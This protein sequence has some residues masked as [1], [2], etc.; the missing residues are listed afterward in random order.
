MLAKQTRTLAVRSLLLFLSLGGYTLSSYS[1]SEY[2]FFPKPY[3]EHSKTIEKSYDAAKLKSLALNVL[4][5]DLLMKGTS[6]QNIVF[7]GKVCTDSP[8]LLPH[9]QLEEE[10]SGDHLVLTVIIP[11][12]EYDPE[13]AFVDIEISIPENLKT[14]LADSSGDI[15]ASQIS[16]AK[17]DDDSGDI[18]VEQNRTPLVIHD[19]SGDITV[20]SSD[21]S[22]EVTDSSGDIR[23]RDIR[24]SINI[25]TDASGD[26]LIST[27]QGPV[28]IEVDS[29]GD[30]EIDDVESD[31]SIGMDSS[32]DIEIER[33]KGSV[34]IKNDGSGS[35]EIS[36]V[37]GNV[38][39]GYVGSG[40][41][42]VRDVGGDFTVAG[43]G[44]GGIRNYNVKGKVDVPR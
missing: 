9:I 43:K 24:S 22:I 40:R 30:I 41:L 33:I 6:A 28:Q 34:Y 12:K 5:G 10:L 11:R 4:A 37:S 35:I 26:I 8:D 25:P 29:S 7:Q 16:L 44:S 39:V 19:S 36:E 14:V 32:G 27:I 17:I 42:T 31:V 2:S 20:M 21:H 38:Q 13:Y 3:C 23:L 18:R 15:E 1:A